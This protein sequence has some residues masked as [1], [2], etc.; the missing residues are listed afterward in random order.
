MESNI[1]TKSFGIG[2]LLVEGWAV[3]KVN[4]QTILTVVLCV[5]IPIDLILSFVP[6]GT[7][8]YNLV[9]RILE[10]FV[11]II[12]TLAIA[13]ITEKTIE[14]ER[15]SWQEALKFGLSKWTKAIGTGFLS[16]V[17]ILGFT[18]LF[19]IPGVIYSL[20]YFFWDYV[21]ALRDR[22]GRE[23]LE[24]SK[25]L[26][27]GQ[28]WRIFGITLF[29]SLVAVALSLGISYLANMISNNQFFSI[30][31]SILIDIISSFLIVMYVLLFLNNDFVY[32]H[33]P[34]VTILPM[35]KL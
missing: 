8:L 5:Y 33:Q 35:D 10:F 7:Q 29:F 13:I 31:P 3:Y 20:Y 19:I 34:E 21:V 27:E 1:K 24:Y 12:A 11:G 28:W 9:V 4:I 16:G 32:R 15:V 25:N 30:I 2:D 22:S 23:A 17:R 18:L 26:V 6:Q 14:G